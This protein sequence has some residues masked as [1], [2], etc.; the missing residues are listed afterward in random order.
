MCTKLTDRHV[1]RDK[2]KSCK[3]YSEDHK[4]CITNNPSISN[5]INT[6]K[7]FIQGYSK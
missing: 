1:L 4:K 2:I 5:L 6:L 3:F 7:G